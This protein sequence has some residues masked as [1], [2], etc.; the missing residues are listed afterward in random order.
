MKPNPPTRSNGDFTPTTSKARS[1]S[2]TYENKGI[3]T[4]PAIFNG[5]ELVRL[6]RACEYVLEQN[7]AHIDV[8]D[9]ANRNLHV[10]RHLEHPQWHTGDRSHWRLLMETVADP[11]CLQPVEEIFG[12]ASLF[13][14]TS[15]FFNPRFE[16]AEGD[17]HR[18]LQFLLPDEDAVRTSLRTSPAAGIQFQIALID[19]DDVEYVPYSPTRY[20]LPGEHFFRC[21]D[22]RSHN[23]ESG[24]P[25]ALR[26][27]LRAGDGLIFNPNG[28]HRGR[29]HTDIPRRT[30]MLTYTPRDT[31]CADWFSHQPWM[32]EPGYLD[33]LS[34][35]ARSY[36]EDFIATYR[37]GWV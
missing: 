21:A 35:S 29:Y 4:Y 10:I 36:F 16:S 2:W 32:L 37:S 20:D 17:W 23:T 14:C 18:D 24:M 11:R 26:L 27:S 6:G 12:G 13:R 1:A 33:A 34:V 8:N 25:G 5:D 19:N 28:I 31:P 3:L 30:L 15:L 9:P 22:G 7:L